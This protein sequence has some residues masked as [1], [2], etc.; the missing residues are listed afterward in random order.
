MI[1]LDSCAHLA[2][3]KNIDR[4][5]MQAKIPFFR[6]NTHMINSDPLSY[7]EELSPNVRTRFRGVLY[8]SDCPT[9]ENCTVKEFKELVEFLDFVMVEIRNFT[10]WIVKFV[11]HHITDTELVGWAINK[12]VYLDYR[13]SDRE[14]I[15]KYCKSI[16]LTGSYDS[17]ES[18]LEAELSRN[19]NSMTNHVYAWYLFTKYRNVNTVEG[20]TKMDKAENLF[21][22]DTFWCGNPFSALFY[23]GFRLDSFLK[24]YAAHTQYTIDRTNL[25]MYMDRFKDDWT[26]HRNPFGLFNYVNLLVK[27]ENPNVEEVSDLFEQCYKLLKRPECLH[28]HAKFLLNVG[29]GEKCVAVLQQNW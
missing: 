10:G 15:T 29:K 26:N 4:W 20:K 11:N 17:Y 2:N 22:F 19:E 27:I 24:I 9:P 3:D 23:H 18:E 21:S 12:R 1:P 28:A 6:G 5:A 14:A 8:V 13:V 7:L 16:G 25:I